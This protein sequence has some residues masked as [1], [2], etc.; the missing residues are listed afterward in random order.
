L[1]VTEFSTPSNRKF[2]YRLC[3][4]HQ[5]VDKKTFSGQLKV[6]IWF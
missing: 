6:S 2:G 4:I 5:A 3:G 1:R